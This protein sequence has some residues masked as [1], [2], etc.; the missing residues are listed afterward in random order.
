MHDVADLELGLAEGFRFGLADQEA[1]ELEDIVID[2]GADARGQGLCLLFLLRLEGDG[3][4]GCLLPGDLAS[5]RADAD[6]CTKI[7]PTIQL[8]TPLARPWRVCVGIRHQIV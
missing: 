6:L 4:H 8:P 5:D 3:G 7:L 1:S 2:G